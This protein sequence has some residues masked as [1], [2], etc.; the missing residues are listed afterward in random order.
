MKK[1]EK[2][3]LIQI[4]SVVIIFMIISMVYIKWQYNQSR[5]YVV[6]E[7]IETEVLPLSQIVTSDIL[8]DENGYKSYIDPETGITAK[9]GIDVSSHQGTIDW[10]KVAD[11]GVEFAIIRVGYRGYSLGL[12]NLDSMFHE[13]IQG[14]IDAGLEVGVYFFSQAISIDEAIDEAN[15]VLEEIKDYDLQY[16]IVYDLE[17]IDYDDYRT[18]DLTSEEKT[19]FAMAFCGRILNEGYEAMIYANL[20]WAMQQFELREIM[21]YPIWFAQYS[22]TPDFVHPFEIWQYTQSGVVDGISTSVDLNLDFSGK[23]GM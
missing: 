11:A 4:L 15:F 14:A 10:D 20:T 6:F 18:S 3:Q 2:Q 21:N 16:P 5:K 1:L 17:K 19:D 9:L 12:L 22:N 13:N 23:Y 8:T 7:P